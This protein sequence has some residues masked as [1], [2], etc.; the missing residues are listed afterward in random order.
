MTALLTF[1]L[2]NLVPNVAV[3]LSN[4]DTALGLGPR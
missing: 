4:L 1:L 2:A 3:T